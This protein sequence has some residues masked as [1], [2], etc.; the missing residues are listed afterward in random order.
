MIARLLDTLR[1]AGLELDARQIEEILWLAPFLSPEPAREEAEGSSD[2]DEAS[3]PP[4]PER[5]DLSGEPPPETRAAQPPPSQALPEAEVGVPQREVG[6]PT[7]RGGRMAFRSP[8]APALPNSL[9]LGRALR[10]LRRRRDSHWQR[11]LDEVATAER[12]AREGLWSPV[13]RPGR[14]RWLELEL[15]LD[16]GRS[17]AIWKQTLSE[18]RTFLRYV[19]AFRDLRTWSLVTEGPEG[20]ARLYRGTAGAAHGGAERDPRELLSTPAERR[21]ILVVSD[22][23]SPAWHTG[24]VG[25]LLRLWGRSGPVAILQMLPQRVWVRTALRH[26]PSVWMHGREPGAANARMVFGSWPGAVVSGPR[27]SVPVPV[28]TLEKELFSN[29][30]RVVAGRAGAWTPGMLLREGG[31]VPKPV[32]RTQEGGE[33]LS[34]V[35]RFEAMASPLAQRL[36]RLFAAVPLSLPVMRL[37]WRTRLPEA[38]QVHLAEVFLSGLLQEVGPPGGT[39]DPEQV[40]YDFLPGVREVLLAS[41]PPAESLDTLQSVSRYVEER[42]GQALDFHA[43]LADP[44]AFGGEQLDEP[45]RPFARVAAAVLRQLGGEYAGLAARLEGEPPEQQGW[46][47]RAPKELPSKNLPEQP[48]QLETPSEEPPA[49][50]RWQA[51]G[52]RVLVL[53]TRVGTLSEELRRLCAMLGRALARQGHSLV[54]GGWPGVEQVVGAAYVETL[55]ELGGD[56]EQHFT[57]VV[58]KGR[59]PVLQEG[60]LVLTRGGKRRFAASLELVDLVVLL[61][62]TGDIFQE[63]EAAR[64]WPKPVLPLPGSGGDASRAYKAV[65]GDLSFRWKSGLSRRSLRRL[66]V[67]VSTVEQAGHAVDSLV[68]L[69][70]RLHPGAQFKPYASAMLGLIQAIDMRAA[71]NGLRVDGPRWRGFIRELV[72]MGGVQP[73]PPGITLK[74]GDEGSVT[75][76]DT[77][78]AIEALRATLPA[79]T[80]RMLEDFERIST[81]EEHGRSGWMLQSALAPLVLEFAGREGLD[82]I[83]ELVSHSSA[84]LEST[85]IVSLVEAVRM[86]FDSPAEYEAWLSAHA[87]LSSDEFEFRK[88]FQQ[89]AERLRRAYVTMRERSP[90]EVDSALFE[91]VRESR[92]FSTEY[93]EPLEFPWMRND[94]TAVVGRRRRA[95]VMRPNVLD[96][97][98]VL[99]NPQRVMHFVTSQWS[100]LRATGY[101]LIH[102]YFPE[103]VSELGRS[104]AYERSLVRTEPLGWTFAV[105]RLLACILH[106]RDELSLLETWPDVRREL[107]QL[108]DELGRL[109]IPSEEVA[110]RQ[111]MERLSEV[112][113]GTPEASQA[114]GSVSVTPW[115][116]SGKW[117]AV[118]G[119]GS[120]ALSHPVEQVCRLLGEGLARGGDGLIGG[121][122]PG[123][124]AV[125]AESYVATLRSLGVNPKEYFLQIVEEGR[126]PAS[127]EGS[128]ETVRPEDSSAAEVSRADAVVLIEGQ[129]GTAGMFEVARVMGKP[130]LPLH[131]TGGDAQ[132]VYKRILED[133]SYLL[134]AGL[135]RR[136]LQGLETVDDVLELIGRIPSASTAYARAM[137]MLLAAVQPRLFEQKSA[138]RPQWNE[139]LGELARQAGFEEPSNAQSQDALR[140]E[141]LAKLRLQATLPRMSER[142][143]ADFERMTDFEEHD[144]LGFLI[145]TALAPLVARSQGREGLAAIGRV[146][147]RAFDGMPS[148]FVTGLLEEAQRQFP[149]EEQY[150]AWVEGQLGLS[151]REYEFRQT[152]HR[153]SLALDL[154]LMAEPVQFKKAID[155]LREALPANEIARE[156]AF[157]GFFLREQRPPLERVLAYLLIEEFG[158][159]SFLPELLHALARER[160]RLTEPLAGVEVWQL[161]SC[162]RAFQSALQLEEQWLQALNEL[163]ALR[164]TLDE[165]PALDPS[166][167]LLASLDSF[168]K[169]AAPPE[170]VAQPVEKLA[171]GEEHLQRR[172]FLSHYRIGSARH[173]KGDL[174]G[175]LTSFQS[176]LVVAQ[177]LV[178][179]DPNDAVLQRDLFLAHHNIGRVLHTLGQL[180]GALV[181]FES[182]LAVAQRLVERDP[183]NAMLQYDL[184]VSHKSFD[185]VLHALGRIS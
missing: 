162:L 138:G 114:Q 14:S 48:V 165:H 106:R 32:A 113:R 164:E 112:V 20:R 105:N 141:E 154:R 168:M 46:R 69:V 124:D 50:P 118:A 74:P 126:S 153:L 119:T 96:T 81:L 29:W 35:Q 104:I 26:H 80:E 71:L 146:M 152:V 90:E 181:A 137:L 16:T 2:R 61:Q 58:S 70:D 166:G 73:P 82:A 127:Q 170:E 49:V 134:H 52:K 163:R 140:G 122:W 47:A 95:D 167:E 21:L 109:S 120:G 67:P 65:M 160:S 182:S 110:L 147:Q 56:P 145:Q 93:A 151:Q 37:V 150:R 98:L 178:E 72:R 108:L 40:Q 156:P 86:W 57:Q 60:K 19:G 97:W 99:P 103:L 139:F 78:P 28:V 177:Q 121:G 83:G 117:V 173:K 180:G 111:L 131:A 12:I 129:G 44:T 51:S 42:L 101:L 185:N 130:V 4:Q 15:V 39:V 22:C 10:P 88:E 13:L 85:F 91:I 143:F 62:G 53:G 184:F 176:C 75:L 123:V 1:S 34:Q 63:F 3:E 23:V 115:Q 11:E 128:L 179:R 41:V 107:V 169:E 64:A 133:A 25:G 159:T 17:M 87:G 144:S 174:Y 175:A 30:A 38:S 183:N 54:G 161:L 27:G 116:W 149:L 132:A 155:S 94:T 5:K 9:Q 102:Q 24:D 157:I 7:Q 158:F 31:S 45:L 8:G 135:S 125:V 33:P 6:G 77:G 55:R 89:V 136:T 66:D 92:L 148:P 68:L 76:G 84:A 43:M 36:V 79:M 172:V 100:S 142:L 171:S 18:L 59:L